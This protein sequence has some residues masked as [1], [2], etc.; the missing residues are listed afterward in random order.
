MTVVKRFALI[1]VFASALGASMGVSPQRVSAQQ[2]KLGYANAEAIMVYLPEYQEINGKV[3]RHV[4]SSQEVLQVKADEFQADYT[5]FEKQAS[6]MAADARTEREAQLTARYNDL[7]RLGAQKEQ[8]AAE[9]E[10]SLI[11]PLLEKVQNA[12]DTVAKEKELDI[13]FRAPGI[14]YVNEKTIVDIT[15]DVAK[16]LGLNLDELLSDN[17]NN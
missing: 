6:L 17:A 14:L 10:Q 13:V 5:K 15:P 12:V 16:R 3:Q 4:Q 1:A 7:Q 11:K 8:E 9:Y 2:L